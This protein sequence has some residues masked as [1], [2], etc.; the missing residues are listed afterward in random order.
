MN[1][2]IAPVNKSNPYGTSNKRSG[3]SVPAG[4]V[5]A[6]HDLNV[7]Q[8]LKFDTKDAKNGGNA[9]TQQRGSSSFVL[10]DIGPGDGES[11][12]KMRAFI[13]ELKNDNREKE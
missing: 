10:P 7:S 3:G 11:K 12:L 5:A 1:N 9:M 2:T 4:K 13:E 6:T 8:S